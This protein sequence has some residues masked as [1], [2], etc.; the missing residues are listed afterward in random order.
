MTEKANDTTTTGNAS[1]AEPTPTLVDRAIFLY[2][3]TPWWTLILGIGLI[4]AMFYMFSNEER[5]DTMD[6]LAD[7]PRLTTDDKFEVTFEITSDVIVLQETLTLSPPV[8]GR[9]D[10]SGTDVLS[11]EEGRLRCPD[12]AG[13]DCVERS[14]QIVSYRDYN[15]PNDAE[16]D[17]T[18]VIEGLLVESDGSSATLRLPDNREFEI[19][20]EQIIDRREGDL[21]CN[22]ALLPDCEVLSGEIVTVERPYVVS[23]AILTRP[24]TLVRYPEDG[25][26]REVR[27]ELLRV[28]GETLI[29]CP[30]DAA[31]ICEPI[32]VPRAEVPDDIVGIETRREDGIVYVRTVDQET[33]SF[34]ADRILEREESMVTCDDDADPRC[35]DFPGESFVL[36]GEVISGRLTNENDNQYYIQFPGRTEPE[37]YVRREIEEETRTP[38]DCEHT[39]QDPPCMIEIQLEGETL[40]GR[41]I[42]ENENT[43]TIET[44][45][46]KVLSIP[47][48]NIE[49]VK[50]R[51]PGECAL[52]NPRGCNEG[53][54]LT[55]IT[56][57]SSYSLALVVGLIFGMMRISGNPILSNV[58]TAYVE[59]VRGVPMV[60]LLVVFTFV[61]VPRLTAV[62]G[63]VGD[64]STEI[65]GVLADLEYAIFG[66]EQRFPEAVLGLA[67]GYG[68]YLAEVF[69]AGIQSIPKGQMEASR[70]LGMSYIESMRH[71]ILP[72]AIR[73]VLPPLGN[74]F[75]AMLKD[76]SLIAFLALPELFQRGRGEFSRSPRIDVWLGVALYYVIMTLILSL[77]VR[78]IERVT[79]L[80]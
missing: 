39:D 70:S 16:P 63:V 69:R 1:Q 71:I 45:P 57:F 79:R 24:S 17:D 3:V 12:D 46:E 6:F 20:L 32:T 64:V 49:E 55:L 18:I 38:E 4:T 61:I 72:Q 52:N 66:I 11:Q 27:S 60:V 30:E 35:Q 15:V 54:W 43:I 22:H 42:S 56:T 67:V 37:R 29:E 41:V 34:A 13:D 28:T 7:R 40:A 51:V 19:S 9:I 21:A 48:D 76:T 47:E 8:G 73:V 31:P 74:N 5:R 65:Y 36:A 23:Q 26:E 33:L 50:R 2:R 75:I 44:V 68:A 80:P 77:L 14:G 59:F 10:I 78:Y 25:Y 58:S 53:L 62:E